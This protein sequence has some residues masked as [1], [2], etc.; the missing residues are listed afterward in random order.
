MVWFEV[1]IPAKELGLPNVTLTVEAQNWIGA[2]RTGLS[3]LGEG[4]EAIANVM[5][6]IKEDN[7]IH[8]TDVSTRRVFRLREVQQP[9]APEPSS[10][11]APENTYKNPV[12]PPA[13]PPPPAPPPEERERERTPPR[14]AARPVSMP[15]VGPVLAPPSFSSPARLSA[16]DFDSGAT[17]KNPVAPGDPPPAARLPEPEHSVPWTA[18]APP[19]DSSA[20][21]E[22]P[23]EKPLLV[24]PKREPPP[25][26]APAWPPTPIVS[27]SS[28]A[29]T[30]PSFTPP[31]EPPA[32]PPSSKA[33][34]V[35]AAV[36]AP[37]P[38]PPA[39]LGKKKKAAVVEPT[40]RIARAPGPSEK[41]TASSPA[42]AGPGLAEKKRGPVP[43]PT[44]RGS[45]APPPRRTSGQFDGAAQPARREESLPGA[46]G[47]GA[48]QGAPIGRAGAVSAQAV[49]DA[50]ADVFD[51]T[52]DLLMEAR[53]APEAIAARLLDIA[54]QHVPAESGSFYLADVNGHELH[55][56]AVRGPKA[57]EIQ[58]KKLSVKVGQGII[59]FCALEGVC[60]SVSDIQKDPRYFSAV[61]DA[62]GYSPRD[63]L[64][65]SAEKDGRLFGALQLINSTDGFSPI[66]MEVLRYIGLTAASLLERHFDN[67]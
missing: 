62:V 7:S 12:S 5:C 18:M 15:D 55:F 41:P 19:Q 59:G 30:E 58:Q 57:K 17:L 28:L 50:V 20:T 22:L 38:A 42:P 43:A 23:A 51:A 63:T 6:D 10:S 52:Q 66:H 33:A 48:S 67:L 39:E 29:T 60:L 56:A 8:V 32:P 53:I 49:A 4:H 11:L 3:N 26:A 25:P 34:P 21:L 45:P 13:A 44:P 61:A 46:V 2:L 65:A 24:P 40:E 37:P 9:K 1:F 27:P 54:L 47:G 64:C 31:T 36:A 14:G 16:A 35:T